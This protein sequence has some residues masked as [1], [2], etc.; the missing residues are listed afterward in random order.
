MAARLRLRK[1]MDAEVR[2]QIMPSGR[3]ILTGQT[4]SRFSQDLRW[5]LL[6]V[7]EVYHRSRALADQLDA[8]GREHV[9]KFVGEIAWRD[10]Y[11][12][13]LHH[14]PG[15]LDDD[16]NPAMRGLPWRQAK[17]PRQT[18][19][20]MVHGNHGLSHRGRGMRQLSA[21]GFMHNRLRMITSMS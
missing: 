5:G 13:V 9:D 7:R 17:D 4:T 21:L 3:T 20:A 1:F 2:R 14:F 19:R 8:P 6:S 10:F 11:F 18:F 16:F 15:V 12:Q